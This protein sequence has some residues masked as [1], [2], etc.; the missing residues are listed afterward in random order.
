[1]VCQS[2]IRGTFKNMSRPYTRAPGLL[3]SDVA[4]LVLMAC[5]AVARQS[6]M[7]SLAS[8]NCLGACA[9]SGMF[10]THYP[11]SGA[12]VRRLRCFVHS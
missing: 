6:S 3:P 2:A 1:M 4:I 11:L 9:D 5:I 8:N 10:V 12:F 7:M